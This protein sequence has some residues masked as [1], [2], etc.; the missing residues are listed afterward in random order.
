MKFN[1]LPIDI[2]ETTYADLPKLRTLSVDTFNESFRSA[3]S[4][5]SSYTKKNY[6]YGQ[7]ASEMINP[8]SHFYFIYY[9]HK[10][11]GY[12]KLNLNSAQTRN[13]GT[14][15]LEIDRIYLRQNFGYIGLENKLINFAFEQAK[16]FHKNIIWSS[17]WEH[18]RPIIH[19]YHQFG[20][21]PIGS[22]NFNLNGSLQKDLVMKVS[23]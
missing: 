12:L 2:K 10:L 18:D 17:I 20:F 3:T 7:L 23:I 21:K 1:I 11:A 4:D 9:N 16:K 13:M 5:L 14:N 19:F 15:S 8:Q 6:N 22:Q